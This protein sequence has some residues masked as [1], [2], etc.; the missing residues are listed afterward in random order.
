MAHVQDILNEKGFEVFTITDDLTVVQA[1]KLMNQHKIGAVIVMS[2]QHIV[3]MFTERDVLTRVVAE[4]RDPA[5]TTV[6]Q[7]MTRKV[8]CCSPETEIDEARAMMRNCRIRHLPV[9]GRDGKVAG[10]VSIGDLNAWALA[11]SEVT[12]QYMSEYI[13]GRV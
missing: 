3:G 10:M 11:D 1:T 12:V 4:Q 13:H 5:V 9:V 6:G 8:M 7:V 2:T